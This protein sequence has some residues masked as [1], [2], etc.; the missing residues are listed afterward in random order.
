MPRLCLLAL[1]LFVAQAGHQ[2]LTL[3]IRAFRGPADVTMETRVVVHRAGERGQPVAQVDVGVSPATRQVAPA[4][5]DAQAVQERDGRVV[6]IRWAERLVVMPYPDEAGHHLEVINF[7][8][9]YGA[10]Q[11]RGAAG[12]KPDADVAL[13]LAGDRG[14]P[15]ATPLVQ[16]NYVLFVVRAGQYDLQV[17][18]GGRMT[19]QTAIDVPL[20]RTRLAIVP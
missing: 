9:G 14:R 3:E 11:V 15:A 6:N 13:F 18:R 16:S 12:K 7:E 5:Y 10:L 17:K 2:L 20:D 8:T 4:I 19:W 1:A